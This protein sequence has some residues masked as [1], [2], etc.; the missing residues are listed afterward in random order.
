ML[1]TVRCEP[2][3]KNGFVACIDKMLKANLSCTSKNEA[4]RVAEIAIDTQLSCKLNQSV[5][6]Q[7]A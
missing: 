4:S 6:A 1:P 5:E 3:M 7:S 2:E